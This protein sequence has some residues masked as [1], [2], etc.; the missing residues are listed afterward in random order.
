MISAMGERAVQATPVGR[1]G[2]KRSARRDGRLAD[3]QLR[4]EIARFEVDEAAFRPA[5]ARRAGARR[6][7]RTR[8]CRRR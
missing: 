6:R 4:A 8:R 7:W 3:P 2:C 5:E 1:S